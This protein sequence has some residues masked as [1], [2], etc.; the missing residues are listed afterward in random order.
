MNRTN[1]TIILFVTLGIL[2]TAC[3]VATTPTPAPATAVPSSK[4]S[5]TC[6]ELTLNLDPALATGYG[7]QSVPAVSAG[8]PVSAISPA[9]TELTLTGYTFTD[10]QYTPTVYVYPLQDYTTLLPDVV[11]PMVS[12]LQA[13]IGGGS[14]PERGLPFL[15]AMSGIQAIVARYQ[16]VSFSNGSGIRFITQSNSGIVPVNNQA[17]FYTFQGLSSDGKYWVSAILPVSSPLVMAD[18]KNPPNGMSMDQFTAGYSTYMSDL[19][20]KFNDNAAGFTPD[21]AVLDALVASIKVQP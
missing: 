12:A 14:A 17:M 20:A 5:A 9:H 1:R 21:L 2:L 7:C 8:G 6:H 15:P 18:G 3:G 19:L 10:N 13:L 16:V 11:P 4:T